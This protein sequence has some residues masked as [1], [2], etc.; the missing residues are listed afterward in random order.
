MKKS[1]GRIEQEKAIIGKIQAIF[2]NARFIDNFEINVKG[3]VAEMTSIKYTFEERI[4]PEMKG[5]E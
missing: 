5:E 1:D 3:G 2:D 4:I